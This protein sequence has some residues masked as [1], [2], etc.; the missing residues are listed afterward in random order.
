M[1][2][3]P[4]LT[5]ILTLVLLLTITVTTIINVLNLIEIRYL[6]SSIRKQIRGILS[7]EVLTYLE[8]R[9]YNKGEQYDNKNKKS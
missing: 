4:P 5:L 8:N 9:T 1:I 6:I 3:L 7:K 2:I